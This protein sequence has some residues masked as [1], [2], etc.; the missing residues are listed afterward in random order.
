MM[1][2]EAEP[3]GAQQEGVGMYHYTECGLD[4]VRLL[5]GYKMVET[6]Y[7]EAVEI[8]DIDGLHRCIGNTIC[9]RS[10]LT[11]PELR[12]LRHEL[13]LSQK[14]LSR[15]L[16]NS[17]QTVANWEKGDI[18]VPV[19]AE[20]VIKKLYLEH[21]DDTTTTVTDLLKAIADLDDNLDNMQRRVGDFALAP[22]NNHWEPVSAC[23]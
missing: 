4:S 6:P 8:N 14:N 12:F 9:S 1:G 11:G 17:D 13:G 7:G 18:T 3:A 22:N 19:P 21:I 20:T 16:G 5:S 2:G 23:A 10:G 15:L